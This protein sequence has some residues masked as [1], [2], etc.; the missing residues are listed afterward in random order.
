MKICGF[1]LLTLLIACGQNMIKSGD[2]NS[3]IADTLSF[4]IAHLRVEGMTC[5]GS[6]I[7]IQ[8]IV[9]KIRGVKEVKASYTDSLT[10]VVFDT[11]VA[12][13]V[14]ISEAINNLGYKVV[15]EIIQDN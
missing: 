7:S 3:G 5:K 6:E 9:G 15:R 10:T 1:M 12:N 14:L 2:K 4:K 11:S 8:Q 13:I